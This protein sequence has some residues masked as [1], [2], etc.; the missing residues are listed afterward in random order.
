M[1]L[2]P[3]PGILIREYQFGGATFAPPV[4]A[5]N[6]IHVCHLRLGM[7]QSAVEKPRNLLA[8]DE[9]DRARRF[10]FDDN[11]ND[12]IACRDALRLLL[13]HYLHVTPQELRFNYSEYGRPSLIGSDPAETV[14]FNLSHTAGAALLAFAR[15]RRIGIDIE[16]VRRDFST[17]EIAERF[18]SLNERMVLRGLPQEQRHQAFFECWTRKEAFI[19]ALG[20]GLSHP[21]DQF[22]VSLTPGKPAALLA[23]RPDAGQARRWLMWNL[24]VPGE[25][26]AALVAETAGS[27]S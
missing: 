14:E 21:L 20:E 11:R 22:D 6:E 8:P 27:S 10:R 5:R 12:Y 26:A 1:A 9:L 15:G 23:T 18:F 4:L 7:N 25:Y 13:G 16:R 3:V 2:Q 24:Q 17:A 19:K